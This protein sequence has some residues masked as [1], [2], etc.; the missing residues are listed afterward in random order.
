MTRARILT[1]AGI[2]HL[3]IAT[4]L[5][6]MFLAG[7]PVPVAGSGLGFTPTF[8]HAP[9]PPPP[10]HAPH[11]AIDK[12]ADLT[13]VPPGG[14][15]TFI[16]RV[17]NDGDA[18][19]DNIVVSDTLPPELEVVSASASQG[20]V[21]VAGNEVRAELGSLAPGA[22]AEVVIAARV[23]TDVPPGTQI[24]NVA[25]V[26]DETSDDV[27]ITVGGFLPESGRIAPLAVVVGFVVVGMVLLAV[28]LVV[29]ARSRVC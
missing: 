8:T 10:P 23:R 6:L 24:V 29:R 15:V 11:L 18:T 5:F 7:R 4:L 26:D 28:G 25:V 2:I 21:T 12:T 16:I 20:T 3:T 17:C 14:Q 19:A 1:T 9:P 27:P 22:C 13:Q